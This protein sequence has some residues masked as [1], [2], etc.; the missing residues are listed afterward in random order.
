MD[1]ALE[2]KDD[3]EI[4]KF[5]GNMISDHENKPILSVVKDIITKGKN[6]FIIDLEQVDTINSS[7]LGLLLG[8]LTK[9]RQHGG[10]TIIVNIPNALS[11]LLV[12]TKLNMIFTT[13]KNYDAA[14]EEFNK[15]GLQEQS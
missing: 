5:I 2:S 11:K 10:E 1:F 3:F 15:L 7:G 14:I 13:A 9:S 8:I 4:I 6:K 12:M